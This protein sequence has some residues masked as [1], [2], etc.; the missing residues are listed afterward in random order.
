MLT[1]RQ[2]I[3]LVVL[4][5]I[6]V[7]AS[8][9][10]AYHR[11]NTVLSTKRVAVMYVS[12]LKSPDSVH[13]L[14]KN[15]DLW[16][17]SE[18]DARDPEGWF[19]MASDIVNEHD[20][21]SGFVIIDELETL[22]YTASAM[23]MMI[24]GL[25]KPVVLSDASPEN[26]QDAFRVAFGNAFG[27]AVIVNNGRILLGVGTTLND[28]NEMISPY[29]QMIGTDGRAN[30]EMVPDPSEFPPTILDIDPRVKIVYIKVFPTINETY[31][32]TRKDPA[33]AV[34]LETDQ[35]GSGWGTN[36]FHERLQELYDQNIPIVEVSP[37]DQRVTP[38]SMYVKMALVTAKSESAEEVM[39]AFRSPQPE[40]TPPSTSREP[41]ENSA[42]RMYGEML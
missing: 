32:P 14:T 30:L 13:N 18:Y 17:Y 29:S 20:R 40:P 22:P 33:H 6:A 23:H 19:R 3:C 27:E 10:I 31:L 11:P 1:Q 39:E 9:F 38:E 34:L 4:I 41:V 42:M 21:Y 5:T 35:I 26:L 7:I 37:V 8:L 12:G 24:D 16:L 25:Q 28:D 2:R 15:I 36:G